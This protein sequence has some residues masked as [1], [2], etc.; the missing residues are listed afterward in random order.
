ME[1][2]RGGKFEENPSLIVDIIKNNTVYYN[3]SQYSARKNI[4]Q[5]LLTFC[6][7]FSSTDRVCFM[8]KTFFR[9]FSQKERDVLKYKIKHILSFFKNPP[10]VIVCLTD[11]DT[12]QINDM[13]KLGDVYF[14][15]NRGEGFGLCS[16]TAK[17]FGN[18]VIC[19][20]F[21]SEVEFLNGRDVILPYHLDTPSGMIGFHNLYDG[22]DQKWAA[23]ND[24]EVVERLRFYPKRDA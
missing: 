11:L 1:I 23:Y 17:K 13:H 22:E 19:G 5:T 6:T 3:I 16:Y 2:Y 24:D 12:E 7:R 18:R 4:D 21:G 20:G 10:P 14:T 9:T 15:L 8:L